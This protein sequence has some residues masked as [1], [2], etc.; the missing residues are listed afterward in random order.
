MI[1]AEQKFLICSEKQHV[2]NGFAAA[3][4]ATVIKE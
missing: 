1:G 3:R 2:C 4:Q